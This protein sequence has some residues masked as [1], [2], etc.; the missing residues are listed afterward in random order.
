VPKGS[1]APSPGSRI[2][3]NKE[4]FFA[5]RYQRVVLEGVGHFPQRESPAA[6]A[7]AMVQFMQA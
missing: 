6:V 1:T 4:H 2:P 3:E 5:S 7:D